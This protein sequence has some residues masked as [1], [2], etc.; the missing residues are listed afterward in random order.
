MGPIC[1]KVSLR[2]VTVAEVA[3][4][5][6]EIWLVPRRFHLLSIR[7]PRQIKFPS[8]FRVYFGE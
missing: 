8:G 7:P 6:K 2:L 4:R 5:H 3:R 1:G